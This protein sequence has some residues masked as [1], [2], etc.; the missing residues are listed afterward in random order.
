MH[1]AA[2]HK[3]ESDTTRV[4]LEKELESTESAV[5]GDLSVERRKTLQEK[6]R[7]RRQVEAQIKELNTEL[8]SKKVLNIT[9]SVY[10]Y[11]DRGIYHPSTSIIVRTNV[12]ELATRARRMNRGC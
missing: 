3:R 2:E 5:E 7:V 12:L 4:R 1:D 11:F 10:N 8:L 6:Q 9:Q